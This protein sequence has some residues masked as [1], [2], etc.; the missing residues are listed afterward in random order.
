VGQLG[1][2]AQRLFTAANGRF[3]IGRRLTNLPHIAVPM[4][5]SRKRL[6]FRFRRA[7]VA[8]IMR[9]LSGIVTARLILVALAIV[10]LPAP[11]WQDDLPRDQVLLSSIKR[12]MK[13]NLSRVPNYTCLETVSRGNRAPE[14]FVISVPGKDVPFRRTDVLRL[15]VAEVSGDE[16]Y[17][18]AGEHNF[19]K[20]EIAEF[21]KGG[22][23]GNGA[24]SLFAHDIFVTSI[25]SYTFIGEERMDG[26]ALLRF[27]FKVPQFISGYRVGTNLGAAIVG[28]HGSFWADPK[29]FDAVRLDIMGD[30]IPDYTG[31]SAV[32]NRVD[33]AMV[34][35][36]GSDVLLPQ[37]GELRT[38]Q[39]AGW[40]S[41]N[42]IS[43]T[44]CRE[45]GVQSV[46]KF[47]DADAAEG[48]GG[49]GADSAGTSYIDIPPGLQ[50]TLKLETP[51]DAATAHV[52]DIIA[53]TVDVDARHKG[54]V[55]V[56]KDAV[57]TGRLRRLEL[58]K[59]GW[60]YVLV[61]LEFIQ[62]EFAGK[63]TRFFAELEKVIL[64]PGAEGPKRVAAK[65]LPGVGMVSAMGNNLRLPV[66]TRM[67]WKTISYA[68]A[69]DIGK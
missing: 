4:Q 52:G 2:A 19:E 66:G 49:G 24:F 54:A 35:I 5:V 11:L 10:A 44:H 28:F 69:A 29:T 1:Q 33:Y 16:L 37:G 60:P 62:I 45:Y 21:G 14:R 51:I 41:R 46:I 6:R 50:L 40:E 64:P 30:D 7:T 67:N 68:Q 39:A 23:I 56:P 17:A 65:D 26:R 25:P 8:A 38:R 15:E 57:I 34:R 20:R 61:G 3:P 55:A 9:A 27:D 12:K 36:G 59:E 42:Q 22:L 18:H 47:D 43:F 32:S 13:Q 63:Q 48:S 58:H 31:L 53:A